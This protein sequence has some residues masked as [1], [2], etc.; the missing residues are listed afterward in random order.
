MF[1]I[2]KVTGE[3]LSPLF[4][5]GDF[6]LVGMRPGFTRGLKPGDTVVFDHPVYG[7]L[8]KQVERLGEAGDEVFVIG[9][10]EDSVDSR[11]FG[12]VRKR[13]VLGKVLWR[14]ARPPR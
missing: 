7:R 6:V 9:L 1:K 5:A 12:P 13:D 8:I 11:R 4:Q 10:R 3:S 2:L 14:I